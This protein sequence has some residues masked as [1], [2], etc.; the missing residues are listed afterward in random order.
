AVGAPEA[1]G[2]RAPSD[3]LETALCAIVGDVLGQSGV[4]V[5]DD[6]FALGGDSVLGTQLVARIRDW[7]DTSTVMVADV[8]AAR[9]VAQMAA[10]LAGR[11]AGS[12][13]LQLVSELYLEVT[14]MDS[15]DVTSELARTTPEPA[16]GN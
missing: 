15:A 8:F 9:T 5:D 14:G 7:L 10:L 12:D 6:F 4:G 11:E 16:L 3:P 13:R 2:Y 1:R